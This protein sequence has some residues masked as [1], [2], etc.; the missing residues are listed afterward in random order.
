MEQKMDKKQWEKRDLKRTAAQWHR[1]QC[2]RLGFLVLFFVLFTGVIQFLLIAA[3]RIGETAAGR[4]FLS[5]NQAFGM[6]L[7]SLSMYGSAFPVSGWLMRRIPK[8]G[9]PER[10]SWGLSQLSACFVIAVGIGL[11][12]NILGNLC[13]L[14]FPGKPDSSD[15][16]GILM[17]SSIWINL[18]VTVLLAPVAE[19]LFFRK[20]LMDRLLGFGDGI[21]VLLS[22]FL[23]AIAHGTIFQFFYT[24]GIG[25]LW[26]YIYAK[27]GRVGYTIGLHM[28]FNFLGG[29]VALEL[30][31]GTAGLWE[32]NWFLRALEQLLGVDVTL[33]VTVGAGFLTV[34]YFMFM[35]A[36][37]IGG[38]V[39]LVS[40]RKKIKM[41]PGQW[42]MSRGEALRL[43]FLNPGMICCI[44][45]FFQTSK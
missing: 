1:K 31:K 26:A 42:P 14:F 8:W 18:T 37:F 39:I 34:V 28:I 20:F 12:G 16:A 9:S 17:E 43:A 2:S 15:L 29:V 35:A 3:V 13:G 6:L 33:T 7:S 36:C 32:G 30:A 22:G 45:I 24:F 5:Q 25:M 44:L 40:C 11:A 19:E 38:I 21:A 41:N 23:F 27:T 4:E 10:Q